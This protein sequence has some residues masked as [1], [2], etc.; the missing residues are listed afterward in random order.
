M[1]NNVSLGLGM[2]DGMLD[3]L[4]KAAIHHIGMYK[5]KTSLLPVQYYNRLPR[6]SPCDVA[7]I[8]DVCIATSNTM[9]AVI[10]IIKSWGAKKIIVVAVLG[11]EDGI[12]QL[13]ESHPDVKIFIG[14]IDNKLTGDGL[15]LPGLG[16][17][18]DR[19][20]GTPQ[21]EEK[22]PVDSSPKKKLRLCIDENANDQG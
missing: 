19:L 16:D 6:N 17:C 4:P 12:K 13:R 11:S 1:R 18:G 10:S 5:A 7:Y 15:L 20:F 21:D 9:H 8:C 2:V 14:A 3:L 22:E